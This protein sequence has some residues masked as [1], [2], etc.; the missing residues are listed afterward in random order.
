MQVAGGVL[1]SAA[2]AIQ[3]LAPPSA[4]HWKGQLQPPPQFARPQP[5]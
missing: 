4:A 1:D 2:A 3:D 5:F